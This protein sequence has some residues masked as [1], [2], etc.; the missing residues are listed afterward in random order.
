MQIVRQG[1][2]GLGAAWSVPRCAE[3]RGS[4]EGGAYESGSGDGD[5]AKGTAGAGRE[6]AGESPRECAGSSGEEEGGEGR[7]SFV[8]VISD[9][10]HVKVGRSDNPTTRLSSLQTGTTKKLALLHQFGCARPKLVE[11]RVHEELSDRRVTGEWFLVSPE[12][13]IAAISAA[14]IAIGEGEPEPPADSPIIDEIRLAAPPV[15]VRFWGDSVPSRV[16]HLLLSL[17]VQLM[18]FEH[19]CRISAVTR[20]ELEWCLREFG[21]PVVGAAASEHRELRVA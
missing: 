3:G 18:A 9:G 8:Y 20:E 4:V 6:A 10:D 1:P 5:D 16:Q 19:E 21:L 15:R 7:M 14:H 17:H 13:A 2:L 12:E 11:A